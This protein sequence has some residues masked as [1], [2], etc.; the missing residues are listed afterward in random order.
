M[1]GKPVIRWR[2]VLLQITFIDQLMNYC[3]DTKTALTANRA[4]KLL[5]VDI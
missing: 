3:V 1:S 5:I 2:Q 4:N